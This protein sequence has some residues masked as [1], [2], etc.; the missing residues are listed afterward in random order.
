M[1]AVHFHLAV[2]HAPLWLWGTATLLF[3]RGRKDDHGFISRLLGAACFFAVCACLSGW[4]AADQLSV[5]TDGEAM[6]QHQDLGWL[7][8]LLTTLAAVASVLSLSRLGQA[9]LW[10]ARAFCLLACALLAY[11]CFWGACIRHTELTGSSENRR[12]H[13]R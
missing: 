13:L 10:V 7:S 6:S 9:G 3:M 12:P 8:A 1:N 5:A 11:T 4:Y 2:N